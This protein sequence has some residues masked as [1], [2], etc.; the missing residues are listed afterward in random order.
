MAQQRPD[1]IVLGQRFELHSEAT[2]EQRTYLVHRPPDCDISTARY[3]VIYVT[4]GNEH[5]RHVSATVDFLTAAGKIPPMLVVGIPNVVR[6][7]DLL[8]YTRAAGPSRLLKFIT[9]EL[10]LKIEHDYRTQP[11]RILT[12]WSDGGLFALRALF[13]APTFFRG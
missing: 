1:S 8:G 10:A 11:Y 12:G 5:F 6:G 2:G 7:R 4:D 13:R 3:P 9:H